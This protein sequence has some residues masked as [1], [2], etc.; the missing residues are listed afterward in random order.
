MLCIEFYDISKVVLGRGFYT[1]AR[2]TYK[3][4]VIPMLIRL[5]LWMIDDRLLGSVPLLEATWFHGEV[6]NKVLLQDQLLKQSFDPWH[7]A[8]VNCCG[9]KSY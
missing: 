1:L 2:E 7:M 3:L 4:N 5:V 9:Y 8:Y 6:R